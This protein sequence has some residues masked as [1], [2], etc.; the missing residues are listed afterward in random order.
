MKA[1]VFCMLL[2]GSLAS[3]A[4]SLR[5]LF[6]NMP[7][8]LSLLLTQN[9]RADFVDFLDS[10]MK[11]RVKNEF[12][13]MSE[14]KELTVDY[15]LL[16]ISSSSTLQLKLLPVNDSVQVVFAVETFSAPAANSFLRVFDTGWHPLPLADYVDALPVQDD[17]L[18][19]ADTVDVARRN[20]ALRFADMFLMKADLNPETLQLEF[21]YTTPD[22]MDKES[23]EALKPYL[24]AEPIRYGWQSGRFV[25]LH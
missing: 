24:V 12:E 6:V 19:K 4:Q 15:L 8:S 10:K 5:T 9:D 1:F 14:L 3:Q 23:A 11:A 25:R 22:Y 20:D 16:Q 7:D 13:G 21:I 17:F 2:L 18:L